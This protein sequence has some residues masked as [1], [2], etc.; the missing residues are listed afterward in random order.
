VGPPPRPPLAA[1]TR[2]PPHGLPAV[3]AAPV[4]VEA[5]PVA[6][7]AEATVI[8]D[9]AALFDPRELVD[10]EDR[11]D[12]ADDTVELYSDP[13]PATSP[14]IRRAPSEPEIET[15]YELDAEPPPLPDPDDDDE[16]IVEVIV[17]DDDGR[18]IVTEKV[19]DTHDA[20]VIV[21]LTEP[22]DDEPTR[23]R[24]I[25]ADDALSVSGTIAVPDPEPPP[26]PPRRPKRVS[27]GGSWD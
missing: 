19:T 3:Q 27:D 2:S 13:D 6:V 14:R 7:E 16:P 11:G 5:A 23:I 25:T 24:P 26:P 12:D 18:A 15:Y 4:A 9:A 21:T 1:A 10:R 8:A 22:S 20:T 17:S